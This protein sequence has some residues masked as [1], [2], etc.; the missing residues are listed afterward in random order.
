[1][2]TTTNTEQSITHIWTRLN[3]CW[4]KAGALSG[5][6]SGIIMMVV[7]GFITQSQTGDF[8]RPYKLIAA[9]FYGSP[10]LAYDG[11]S[12]F[13]VSGILLHTILSAIYG[14]VFAQLVD[15]N[16]KKSSFVALSFVTSFI[17]WIFGLRFFA[18]STDPLLIQ[19]APISVGLYFHLAF[20]IVYGTILGF[21]QKAVLCK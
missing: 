9:V 18:W 1:M 12:K 21:F 15:E 3:T 11:A 17:I 16:S 5:I 6:I 19:A 4:L 2:T 7:A 14:T 20:G 8:F 13:L 10:A